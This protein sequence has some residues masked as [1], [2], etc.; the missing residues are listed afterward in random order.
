MT[1]TAK[2]KSKGHSTGNCANSNSHIG[3]L[4]ISKAGATVVY[5]RL[6]LTSKPLELDSRYLLALA[7]PRTNP[8]P[9]ATVLSTPNTLKITTSMPRKQTPAI[10][11]ALPLRFTTQEMHRN[12]HHITWK[13]IND[14][15]I[16]ASVACTV[17]EFRRSLSL[18]LTYYQSKRGWM[19]SITTFSLPSISIHPLDMHQSSWVISMWIWILI[20]PTT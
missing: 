13:M 5:S 8:T 19:T 6:Y 12:V 1:F 15:D 11:G 10:K 7:L 3:V 2:H 14:M 18:V 17:P 20:V 9:I 4:G 16:I